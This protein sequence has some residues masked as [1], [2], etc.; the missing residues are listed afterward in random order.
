[1]LHKTIRNGIVAFHSNY[2]NTGFDFEKRIIC[3]AC[4]MLI[5]TVYSTK[6]RQMFRYILAVKPRLWFRPWNF[7]PFVFVDNTEIGL[8]RLSEI[9]VGLCTSI[10][11]PFYCD[12][13]ATLSHDLWKSLS[14]LDN[15]MRPWLADTALHQPSPFSW[16]RV[17]TSFRGYFLFGITCAI[18][19]MLR[20]CA[21]QNYSLRQSLAEHVQ[22]DGM[23]RVWA[24]HYVTVLF[25]SFTS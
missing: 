3:A 25:N 24:S 20:K 12:W 9:F 11:G 16:S 10:S 17:T 5:N 23:A 2:V 15:C 18:V 6:K 1:M 22:C 13:I 7:C 4:L 8:G 21:A 19:R 14:L